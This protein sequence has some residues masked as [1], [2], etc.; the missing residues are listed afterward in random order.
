VGPRRQ[1][2]HDLG[3]AEI[4]VR[5]TRRDVEASCPEEKG[6]GRM[7][8]TSFVSY[9]LV[10]LL[11]HPLRS[12]ANP[13]NRLTN[14]HQKRLRETGR[15]RI[16]VSL[17]KIGAGGSCS[18]IYKLVGKRKRWGDQTTQATPPSAASSGRMSRRLPPRLNTRTQSAGTSGQKP[19]FLGILNLSELS[20]L[21]TLT[22]SRHNGGCAQNS[23]QLRASFVPPRKI[24]DAPVRR[25]LCHLMLPLG[26][27]G[28]FV[29]K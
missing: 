1:G 17:G 13:A 16:G 8:E 4:P 6:R 28:A 27:G 15:L 22:A 2:D 29:G 5:V 14:P 19:L 9:S 11:T 25:L 12:A 26:A 24:K 21:I 3:E 10:A 7:W 18:D 23:S 20:R